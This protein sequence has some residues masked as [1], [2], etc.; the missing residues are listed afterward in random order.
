MASSRGPQDPPRPGDTSQPG[1][2]S[3]PSDPSQPGDRLQAA[4]GPGRHE[5]PAIDEAALAAARQADHVLAA[6]RTGGQARW[7][8]FLE[9][10]PDRLRDAQL[11]ELRSIAVRAR[12]AFG[13]NDSIR[14]VLPADVTEPFRLALD[15]LLKVIAREEAG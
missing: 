6:V 8:A 2:P 3:L 13:P 15:R 10:I 4:R 9:R 1:G 11:G 14:D 5:R 7:E 12:A